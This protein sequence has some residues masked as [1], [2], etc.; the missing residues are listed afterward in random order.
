MKKTQGIEGLIMDKQLLTSLF[1][2]SYPGD[3][4]HH[5][6]YTSARFAVIKS[7]LINQQGVLVTK[8]ICLAPPKDHP[9][10]KQPIMYLISV[11]EDDI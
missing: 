4:T 9:K 2:G 11:V 5:P 1:I 3:T 8:H 6:K 10:S 7:H